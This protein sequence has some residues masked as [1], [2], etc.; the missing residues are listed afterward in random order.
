MHGFK[1]TRS[2]GLLCKVTHNNMER[3]V[4]HT[5][6]QFHH[7]YSSIVLVSGLVYQLYQLGWSNLIWPLLPCWAYLV[8]HIIPERK[9]P[10]AEDYN[11]IIM[12]GGFSGLGAAA[13]MD[14]IGVKYFL[15]EKAED[16]G[17]TWWENRYP[18]A[19]CDINSHLYS[20]SYF[21]NPWW[22]RE[23]AQRKEIRKY[24]EEFASYYNLYPNLMFNHEV[25]SCDWI[26]A[27]K[28]WLVRTKNGKEF[29]ANF[30]ISAC[31]GIH[32]INMPK[33]EG[34]M[35]F[36]GTRV[37]SAKWDP[38]LVIDGKRIGVIGTGAS[39]VQI[40]PSVASQVKDLYVFQRSAAW[41][42]P[43]YDSETPPW[44]MVLRTIFPFLTTWDRWWNY[45]IRELRFPFF[46]KT[47]FAFVAEKAMKQLTKY[48]KR[49]VQDQT[50]AQK[51]VPDYA[52][53]CKRVTPSDTYLQTF[54]RD[55]VH[56]ITD[57]IQ[58]FTENGILVANGN[59]KQEIELDI[60]VYA[61]GFDPLAT[62]KAVPTKGR[63]GEDMHKNFGDA[64]Q[65]LKGIAVP[66]Q[67]NLFLVLGPN[68]GLSHN[69]IITVIECEINY[70]ADCMKHLIL[71]G[72]KSMLVKK[73][74]M[75]KYEQY[76]RDNLKN[77]VVS[78]GCESWY[79]NKHGVNLS[80]WP[81][82]LTNLWWNMRRSDPNDFQFD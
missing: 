5:L 72:Q 59:Q 74:A 64:P 18:G 56:L 62:L 31:G 75:E 73:E 26:E 32:K 38:A 69:S 54:N 65:T 55:N 79:Q 27:D 81:N 19:A 43:R 25:I 47:T 9:I 68:T 15:L 8:Y 16:L 42:P 76:M 61:T 37:H 11:A 17:G 36:N 4:K 67:P 58:K 21:L 45:W 60:V 7:K 48:H 53:G 52:M 10:G 63:S 14:Q 29:K 51:L 1:F 49:L 39:A 6:W 80:I 3:S 41:V 40:V 35:N 66:H 22:T 20:F 50:I 24:M 44:K 23:Y 34:E 82:S 30:V 77:H 46:F 13:K 2:L 28:K 33:F 12:G 78:S 70:I 71:G 57:K